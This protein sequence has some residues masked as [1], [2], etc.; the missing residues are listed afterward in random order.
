MMTFN[1]LWMYKFFVDMSKEKR[2]LKDAWGIN[3]IKQ[4]G[5]WHL[6]VTT[7]A[8]IDE[9]A[10]Y[11]A[12]DH[13]W[14]EYR[15]QAGPVTFERPNHN[16][17]APTPPSCIQRSDPVGRAQGSHQRHACAHHHLSFVD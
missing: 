5:S 17:R 6:L 8:V 12:E 14:V 16:I 9:R 15:M 4:R 13:G 1:G 2:M 10:G 11:T 3:Y 7:Q